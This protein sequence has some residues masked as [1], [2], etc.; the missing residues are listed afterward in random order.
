[1]SIFGIA[2]VA[3]SLG[4]A[5]SPAEAGTKARLKA[6]PGKPP[7]IQKATQPARVHKG[8]SIPKVSE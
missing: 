6:K 7:Q 3:V 2:L 8:G 1:M 5:V 4:I